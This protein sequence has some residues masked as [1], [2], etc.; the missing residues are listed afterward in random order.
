MK[1]KTF[2]VKYKGD[3]APLDKAKLPRLYHLNKEWYPISCHLKEQGVLL[4][5]TEYNLLM[6]VVKKSSIG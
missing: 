2:Q 3:G 1:K 6:V 4:D 5:G